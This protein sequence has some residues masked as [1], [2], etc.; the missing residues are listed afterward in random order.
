MPKSCD[1]HV[2]KNFCITESKNLEIHDQQKHSV[3]LSKPKW[4]HKL[5]NEQCPCVKTLKA[6]RD[7]ASQLYVVTGTNSTLPTGAEWIMPQCLGQHFHYASVQTVS[8]CN[9]LLM[10]NQFITTCKVFPT[11][12]TFVCT[13][14]VKLLQLRDVFFPAKI[15]PKCTGSQTCALDPYDASQTPKLVGVGTSFPHA[16][17]ILTS[18]IF[19]FSY[20]PGT[21]SASVWVMFLNVWSRWVMTV[22]IFCHA[23]F[24][25]DFNAEWTDHSTFV[26][27]QS[28]ILLM[29][30]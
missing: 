27:H 23:V 21:E 14:M 4:P 20:C 16:A 17:P 8:I 18:S 22:L 1:W 28:S 29:E 10:I 3:L 30:L 19:R 6:N 13:K 12:I 11:A 24:S 26:H 7:I 9:Q 15:S 5:P 25:A 2:D